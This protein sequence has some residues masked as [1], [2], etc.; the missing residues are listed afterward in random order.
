MI[1]LAT[2]CIAATLFVLDVFTPLGIGK[3]GVYVVPLLI[4]FRARQR[5]YP[6]AF[7]ALCSALLMARYF[8]SPVGFDPKLAAAGRLMGAI[9]LW[10]IAGLLVQRKRAEAALRESEAKFR[11]ISEEALLGICVIQDGRF[12]Y[13]NP[14][15]ADIYG[16]TQAE[17][18]ALPS[19]LDVVVEEDRDLVAENIR[20]RL[21]DEVKEMRYRVHARRKD[22]TI[23]A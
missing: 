12:V 20:R 17:L 21:A 1:I 2:L 11:V 13:V 6:F 14:K 9:V 16:Y 15:E 8:Y 5:W 7:A 10:I 18:L 4:A 23:I 22:G 3:W 19:V